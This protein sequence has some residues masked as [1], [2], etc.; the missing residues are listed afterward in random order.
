M[1]VFTGYGRSSVASNLIILSSNKIFNILKFLSVSTITIQ[2]HLMSLGNFK[3]L[4]WLTVVKLATQTSS[5]CVYTLH[6]PH[7]KSCLKS[8]DAA[9]RLRVVEFIVYT[10]AVAYLASLSP[11]SVSIVLYKDGKQ[12][13]TDA[14][15]DDDDATDAASPSS[16]KQQ[17]D[18]E[19][20]AV[21]R[22]NLPSLVK[23]CADE[24]VLVRRVE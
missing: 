9:Y 2:L 3:R 18:E 5:V 11:Q 19:A 22:G 10:D 6:E 23:G 14:A 20:E 4:L 13:A 24:R 15:D 12:A 8:V 16:E 1:A 7:R 17:Q 21:A